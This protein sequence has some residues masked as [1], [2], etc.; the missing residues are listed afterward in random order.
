[1]IMSLNE[2]D[3]PLDNPLGCTRHLRIITVGA[4]AS[5]LNMIRTLRKHLDNYENVVYEKNPDIGGTWYENR[6]PGCKCDVPSQNYQFTWR[7]NPDW[8]G[9]Y[10]E[11]PEILQYLKTVATEQDFWPSVKLSHQVIGAEWFEEEGMWHVKVKNLSNE[12]IF[13]DQCH[14]LLD[15]TGVLK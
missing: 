11:A 5:G 1:M 9:F 2:D 7:H 14:F 12:E 8:S 13:E 4:G 6:Y 10:V 3:Y 15:A